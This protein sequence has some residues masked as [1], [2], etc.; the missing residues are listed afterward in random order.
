MG[1]SAPEPG[2][3][4]QLEYYSCCDYNYALLDSLRGPNPNSS[5][6]CLCAPKNSPTMP[7]AVLVCMWAGV[8]PNRDSRM[9]CFACGW[10]VLTN[11]APCGRECSRNHASHRHIFMWPGSTPQTCPRLS[12][13]NG[14]FPT[15]PHVA[16]AYSPTTRSVLMRQPRPPW[17]PP[18]S[19]PWTSTTAAAAATSGTM[20]SDNGL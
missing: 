19:R 13:G 12:C 2:P 16:R 18:P 8:H 6:I 14:V 7:L 4:S 10:G 20:N 17:P 1:D 3:G 11:R 15:I 5:N 9:L